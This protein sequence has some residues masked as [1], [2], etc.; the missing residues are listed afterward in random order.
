M[1][2]SGTARGNIAGKGNTMIIGAQLYT[3]RKRCTTV[4][5]LDVALQ[6][7]AEMGYKAVQLSGV[8]AYDPYWMDEK[9]KAYGLVAPITHTAYKDIVGNTDEVIAAHKVFGA[10]YVGLGSCP[11]FKDGGCRTETLDEKFA[12]LAPAIKK[13]G[14]AG[15]KFMYHNH[16]MEFSRTPDG[17]V[18]LDYIARSLPAATTGITLDTYW[19]TAGGGDPARW[20]RHLAGRVDCVH[21]KD[22]VYN[23]EDK[24][25]RMAP[26]GEGNLNYA[27]ICVACED[28]GVKYGFVEQDNCYGRD[29]FECLKASLDALRALGC[30]D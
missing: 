18:V 16:N 15:L 4:E 29:E 19:V 28:A 20:L 26:I 1:S 25:V 12:E 8:C 6:K 30:R 17:E 14:D 23:G 24:A 21:F 11:G 5:D 3:A 27:E 22:M 7:C 13:I 2:G 9:L 10:G